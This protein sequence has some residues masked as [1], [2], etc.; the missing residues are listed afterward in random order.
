MKTYF[1]VED[2][3]FESR[4]HACGR[5]RLCRNDS[6]VFH[7]HEV[8]NS[9]VTRKTS[10]GNILTEV[11]RGSLDGVPRI[12][13]VR[14]LNPTYVVLDTDAKPLR[15]TG[16]TY[17]ATRAE[18]E[19][20]R[21]NRQSKVQKLAALTES[22]IRDVHV[23]SLADILAQD[24]DKIEARQVEAEEARKELQR[25]EEQASSSVASALADLDR[26][27]ACLKAKAAKLFG[28]EE[29]HEKHPAR[30]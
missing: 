27:A 9:E 1:H 28:V 17:F 24:A 6:T 22:D 21:A 10:K 16:H 14:E 2:E 12:V 23:P 5:V 29:A 15:Y 3:R 20:E 26:Q 11:V 30:R 4:D 19:V 18:A 13:S 25:L 7:V 8:A